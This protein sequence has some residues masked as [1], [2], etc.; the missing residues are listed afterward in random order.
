MDVAFLACC[1]CLT[2]RDAADKAAALQRLIAI[3]PGADWFLAGEIEDCLVRNF[4][5][6]RE[7]V[8]RALRSSLR[9]H[10]GQGR[11]LRLF[12]TLQRVTAR[13]EASL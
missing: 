9:E 10:E 8:D 7:F 12:R 2:S 4:A 3:L 1:L 5:Q 6:A 11:D 13:A